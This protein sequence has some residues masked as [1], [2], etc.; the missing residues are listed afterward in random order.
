M[1]GLNPDSEPSP[2]QLTEVVDL[3]KKY[4]VDVIFFEEYVSDKLAKVIAKEIGA[5]ILLL[6]PGANLSAEQI[7]SGLT[8]IEI[9]EKNLENLK[10]GL[11]CK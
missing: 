4:K 9:M 3:A 2:K 8:F 10:N 1:Y 11:N 5:N 7:I 6:N